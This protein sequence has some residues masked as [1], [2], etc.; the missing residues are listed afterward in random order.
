MCIRGQKYKQGLLK[1]PPFLRSLI[2]E[3]MDFQG[4]ALANKWES[5][6]T[7]GLLRRQMELEILRIILIKPINLG[8]AYQ[9]AF[10]LR[11]MKFEARSFEHDRRFKVFYIL[12]IM[13]WEGLLTRLLHLKCIR[14]GCVR[15]SH[16]LFKIQEVTC[17]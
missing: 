12:I 13:E 4:L 6:F 9:T 17:L 11:V 7:N 2:T 10:D 1:G 5:H 8:Q 16:L 14:L 15:S 3:K